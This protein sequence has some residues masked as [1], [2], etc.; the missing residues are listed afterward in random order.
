MLQECDINITTTNTK[1]NEIA[2]KSHTSLKS[3]F[4]VEVEKEKFTQD[5]NYTPNE[6]K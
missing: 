2:T 5:I 1:T 4:V 3:R 6:K